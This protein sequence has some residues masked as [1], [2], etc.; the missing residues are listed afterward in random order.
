MDRMDR[1]D[2]ELETTAAPDA[3]WAAVAEPDGLGDW[4]EAEVEL[5]LQPGGTGS[6][7]F[8][9]GE[10]RRAM[11]EEVIPGRELTFSWW[12]IG[13]LHT[14]APVSSPTT[15]TITVE[16]LPTGGSRFRVREVSASRAHAA[17]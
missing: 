7:R 1:I 17:A 8:A 5:D 10:V 12:R 9:D 3:V 6:F 2:R 13:S 14:R 15:V 16:P 4:L 11:V